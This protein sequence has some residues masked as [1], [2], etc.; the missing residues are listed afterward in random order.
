MKNSFFFIALLVLGCFFASCTSSRGFVSTVK[1]AEIQQVQQFEPLTLVGIIEKDDK[2]TYNDSLT[3]ISQELFETALSNNKTIPVTGRIVVE[4]SIVSNRVQYEIFLMMKYINGRVRIEEIPI[5][6]T[7][8]SI[9]ESRNERFGLLAYSRGFVRTDDN[10]DKEVE[11]GAAIALLTLGTYYRMPY[12]YVTHG[13]IVIVDSLNNNIAFVTDES[14]K[15]HPL[16]AETYEKMMIGLV[17]LF[18]KRYY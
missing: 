16:K 2:I 17:R 14:Y 13:G 5:P 18:R 6:P 8:D 4:D 11:K 10:Y 15:Y 1:R 3:I 7:I 12:Q 9:L